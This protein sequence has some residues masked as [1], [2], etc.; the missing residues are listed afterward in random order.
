MSERAVGA[1]LVS[2]RR[3]ATLH[4]LYG[5][6]HP[7]TAAALEEAAASAASLS[8]SRPAQLTVVDDSVYLD[9]TLL[10]VASLAH[11]GFL[12]VM[13]EHGVVSLTLVP[14]VLSTDLARLTAVLAGESRDFPET[15]SVRLNQDNLSPEDL[16]GPE[17]QG[18]AY[19]A[20]LDLLRAVSLAVIERDRASL[21]EAA[22]AVR[23]LMDLCVEDPAAAL[24]LSTMKSHSEYTFYHSV[25]TCIL[26]LMLGR[27]A[28]LDTRDQVLL[29]MGALLHDIG[30]IGVPESVLQHPG[31]LSP[32]QWAE[33]HRH[34]HEGAEAILTASEPG[35][36]VVAVV[37]LEHHA[38]YD[39]S[40]YP[41]LLYFEEP[42]DHT[43]APGHRHHP[44][45]L[46]TRFT[47]VADGYDAITS[48]RSY[49]RPETPVRALQVL[50]EG[51]GTMY[52]PDVVYA[53]IDIMGEYPPG[54]LL[55]LRSGET[56]LVTRPAPD[57]LGP[58][59]A[60]LVVDARGRQL[61]DPR[62]KTFVRG[63]VAAHLT[64]D[65]AGVAPAAFLAHAGMVAGT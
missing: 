61:A 8:P 23:T 16:A 6:S 59:P 15:G 36:E 9:R 2:L 10:P 28:G 58:V 1:L 45:H 37:A 4:R 38:R 22:L 13:R 46:F 20:T 18:S 26:T 27:A 51:A 39:G 19:T 62:P 33:I 34:P 64:A 25:N 7:L 5:S 48:R 49:R 47:A 14:P 63:E 11:N 65:R 21:S 55:R 3:V 54:S 44:L 53:F 43:G 17:G 52:D 56:V 12:R 50:L 42:P 40:G 29:G 31:R 30:K 57:P 32:E 35:Q 60:L 41:N 24:L